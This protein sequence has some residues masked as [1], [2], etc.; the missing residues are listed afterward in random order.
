MPCAFSSFA[1]PGLQFIHRAG[2]PVRRMAMHSFNEFSRSHPIYTAPSAIMFSISTCL[3]SPSAAPAL[4]S[5][6][7]SLAF[8]T[9]FS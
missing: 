2:G 7:S 3:P 8:H 1:R 9:R 6:E 5:R 4:R